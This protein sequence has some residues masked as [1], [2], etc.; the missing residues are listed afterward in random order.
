MSDLRQPSFDR[1]AGATVTPA[2]ENDVVF[3]PSFT[4]NRRAGGYR[5]VIR[6]RFLS[7]RS[8]GYW[9]CGHEHGTATMARYCATDELVR[10]EK[11]ER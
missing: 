4:F 10:R 8:A 9:W 6:K 11:G 5:G 7:G 3:Y 1:R 2:P